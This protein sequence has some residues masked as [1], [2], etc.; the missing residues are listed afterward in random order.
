MCLGDRWVDIK[1]ADLQGEPSGDDLGLLHQ[2]QGFAW[3]AGQSFAVVDQSLELR[4]LDVYGSLHAPQSPQCDPPH[5]H[6]A[7][8]GQAQRGCSQRPQ[9]VRYGAET[10]Q[11]CSQ[12]NQPRHVP[13]KGE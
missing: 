13:K 9:A 11:H 8:K 3:Q 6:P 1:R 10:K 12:A 5:T 4:C 7:Q 2:P